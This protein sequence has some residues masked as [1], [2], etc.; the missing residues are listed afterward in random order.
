MGWIKERQLP[1][2]LSVAISFEAIRDFDDLRQAVFGIGGG[3]TGLFKRYPILSAVTMARGV[4][5]EKVTHHILR[6]PDAPYQIADCAFQPQ[7]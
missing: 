4:S 6:N 5:I 2:V 1:F 7:T 3:M